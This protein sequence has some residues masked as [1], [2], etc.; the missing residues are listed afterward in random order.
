MTRIE[1]LQRL[2]QPIYEAGRTDWISFGDLIASVSYDENEQLLG[3]TPLERFR[4]AV[5]LAKYLIETG[6][7]EFGCPEVDSDGKSHFRPIAAGQD[8]LTNYAE[9][10]FKRGGISDIDLI[11][12]LWLNKV[13]DEALPTLNQEALLKLADLCVS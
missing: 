4:D 7:F 6:D 10:Y 13:R 3:K 2:L 5:V 1:H 12:G 8:R 9:E 11:S